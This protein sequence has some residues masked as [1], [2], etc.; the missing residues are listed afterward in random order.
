M[1]ENFRP[2]CS[3]M[4]VRKCGWP[5]TVVVATRDIN[6]GDMLLCDAYGKEYWLAQQAR[7]SAGISQSESDTLVMFQSVISNPKRKQT[8]DV[9][10]LRLKKQIQSGWQAYASG[11][12]DREHIHN[13]FDIRVIVDGSNAGTG[14]ETSYLQPSVPL[15][16]DS[17]KKFHRWCI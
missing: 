14:K 17:L 10:M 12:S 9:N 2:N 15:N 16:M 11:A 1:Q 7:Q 6:Q 4:E 13:G 3:F 8:L 5:Y